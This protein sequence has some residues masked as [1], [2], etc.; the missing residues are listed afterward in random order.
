M[1]IKSIFKI[2]KPII[3]ALHFMPL[4]GYPKFVGLDKIIDISIKDLHAFQEGGING[5]I[6][7][8]NYD[9]PHNINVGP[10]IIASMT[11]LCSELAKIATVPLGVNVLWNDFKASLAIA[12]TINAKFIRVPVF[13]DDVETDFGKIY[14][15]PNEVL[16]YRSKLSANEDIAILADIQVKHSK[17]LK[18]R[19]I[20]ESARLAQDFGADAVIIT[21][22]WTGNAPLISDLKKVKSAVKIPVLIGSGMTIKN[23]LELLTYSDGAIVS[24]SVKNDDSETS[25]ERNVRSFNSRININK[26]KYLLD[27]IK[28]NKLAFI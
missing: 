13:V 19:P 5:I 7:E 22:K 16:D 14:C 18:S 4:L 15:N 8:N 20:E 1:E 24:T 11:Y 9:I 3:G 6:L 26:V 23:A 10:E 27:E 12:K 21:G 25:D 2:D 28:K 17:M